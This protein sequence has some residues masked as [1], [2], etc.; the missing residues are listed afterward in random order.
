M[1][2]EKLLELRQQA[3]S[4]IDSADELKALQE[5][6]VRFLGKKGPIT[7]IL[8]GMGK[9]SK[10]ERPVVGQLAN[11]VRQLITAR[12]EE[13][14]ADLEARQLEMKLESEKIDVTLPGRKTA[15]GSHHCSHQSFAKWKIYLS[16]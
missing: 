8:K 16:V 4:T 2:K 13:K 6:H 15:P 1:L 3:L 11:E 14:R 7:E 9:L 10:E 12:I 5:A